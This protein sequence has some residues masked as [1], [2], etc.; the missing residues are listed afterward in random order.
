MT[1]KAMLASSYQ[2]ERGATGKC[3]LISRAPAL[4]PRIFPVDGLL[5]ALAGPLEDAGSLFLKPK[6]TAKL[7]SSTDTPQPAAKY[8][9]PYAIQASGEYTK[10][11]AEIMKR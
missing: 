3:T 11:I 1:Y 4:A 5:A 9:N 6:S 10:M 2:V 8:K 7:E